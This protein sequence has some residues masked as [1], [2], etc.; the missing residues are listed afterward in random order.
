MLP[1][2]SQ[3]FWYCVRVVIDDPSLKGT[4][5]TFPRKKCVIISV[6]KKCIFIQHVFNCSCDIIEGVVVLRIIYKC[7]KTYKIK[8]EFTF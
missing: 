2:L 7:G 8:K 1:H 4:L 5:I 6:C 3:D